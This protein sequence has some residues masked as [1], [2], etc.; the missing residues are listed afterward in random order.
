MYPAARDHLTFPELLE[1]GFEP[2]KVREVWLMLGG[3]Y[4][5]LFNPLEK[6]DVETA[7]KALLAHV[8]Q[9][10][11]T[12]RATERMWQG[13]AESGRNAGAEYAERFKVFRLN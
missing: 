7:V 11:D 6:Q 13:R 2:H 12:E 1:E 4:T 10:K 3:E 9:I 8:S 5:D